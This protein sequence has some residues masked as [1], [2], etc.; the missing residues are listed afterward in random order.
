VIALNDVSNGQ[1]HGKIQVLRLYGLDKVANLSAL[2]YHDAIRQIQAQ[3]QAQSQLTG[4]EYSKQR[5]QN[6]CPFIQAIGMKRGEACLNIFFDNT[7]G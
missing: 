2:V 5:E 4:P 1:R 7:V 6:A 3:K